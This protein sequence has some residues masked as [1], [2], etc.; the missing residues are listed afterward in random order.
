M[1]SVP[2]PRE[3]GEFV[4]SWVQKPNNRGNGRKAYSNI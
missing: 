4:F 1:E 2:S 3:S